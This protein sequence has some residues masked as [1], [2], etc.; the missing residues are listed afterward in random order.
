VDETTRWLIVV[1][2]HRRELYEVLRRSLKE[3][4]P[5]MVIYDRRV[6]ERR[7]G[8]L[9]SGA[10]RRRTDR[11]QRRPSGVLYECEILKF[12]EKGP[13]RAA[14]PAS[15][16]AARVCPECGLEVEFEMPRFPQPPARLEIETLHAGAQHLIEIHAFTATGRPLLSQ[17]IQAWRS[18]G[19]R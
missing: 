19:A 12:E 8:S 7:R 5:V 9:S 17:R 2:P 14:P 1:Q 3:E 10:D 13:A 11:R 6:R 16:P 15:P 18:G 4:G